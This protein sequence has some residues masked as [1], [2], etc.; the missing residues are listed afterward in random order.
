MTLWFAAVM[1]ILVSLFPSVSVWLGD[2]A[3]F[4]AWLG[5]KRGIL[6]RRQEGLKI[7]KKKKVFH[8]YQCLHTIQ[9]PLDDRLF[10]DNGVGGRQL[11]T[12]E[13]SS[14]LYTNA[15]SEKKKK[16]TPVPVSA[17]SCHCATTERSENL[18]TYEVGDCRHELNLFPPHA[19]LPT[20]RLLRTWSP[21]LASLSLQQAKGFGLDDY[22][23]YHARQAAVGFGLRR[24]RLASLST[25]WIFGV[26]LSR[27][28]L[29]C[30]VGVNPNFSSARSETANP[31]T[32]QAMTPRPTPTRVLEG[33]RR[34]DLTS[35]ATCWARFRLG[36]GLEEGS[37]TLHLRD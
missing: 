37:R 4:D 12:A 2:A 11:D 35:R 36:M 17:R 10:V 14:Y 23:G 34:Y 24:H 18:T 7:Q 16:N 20:A 25:A 31:M 8:V 28:A 26:T 27:A 21:S 32:P 13:G 9:Q 5:G 15:A 1:I 29:S 19:Q 6:P 33:S 22:P 3:G 30:S